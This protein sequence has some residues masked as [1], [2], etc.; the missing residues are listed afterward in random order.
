[1]NPYP[2]A[3]NCAECA[4]LNKCNACGQ[5]SRA[6]C[7]NGRCAKCHWRH[8]EPRLAAAEPHADWL[9]TTRQHT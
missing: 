4:A 2:H 9:A 8:C 6:R 5:I 3:A 1:M 7:A